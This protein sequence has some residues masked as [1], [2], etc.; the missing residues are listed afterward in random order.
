MSEWMGGGRWL[1][2]WIDG[3]MGAG[4][5]D[6]WVGGGWLAGWVAGW[7]VHEV[8]LV[9]ILPPTHSGP[10]FQSWSLFHLKP[11][12]HTGCDFFKSLEFV[13]SREGNELL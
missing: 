8:V 12:Q 7:T 5:M 9:P 4:W 3:W 6:R 10:Q 1:A 2:G 11:P 13:D